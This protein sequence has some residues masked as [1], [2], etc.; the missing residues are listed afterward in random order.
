MDTRTPAIVAII[1]ALIGCAGVVSAAI[2]GVVGLQMYNDYKAGS[3]IEP[4]QA[5]QNQPAPPA[6]PRLVGCSSGLANGE[7]RIIQPGMYVVGDIT[8]DG[9]L[10]YDNGDKEGTVVYFERQASVFAQWGAACYTGDARLLSEV[11]QSELNRGCIQGCTRVRVVIVRANGRQDA[12]CYYPGGTT[13]PLRG[14][15]QASWCD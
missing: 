1:V 9:V 13:R 6:N 10:Q 8:V 4:P 11:I 3:Q 7:T 12:I 15:G 5:Q 2:I 14:D